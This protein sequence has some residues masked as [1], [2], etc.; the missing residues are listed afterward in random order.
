MNENNTYQLIAV[1]L[2][3]LPVPDMADR[4]WA[5][6]EAQLDIDLPP[7]NGSDDPGP[8]P[9]PKPV[10]KQIALCA[11]TIAVAISFFQLIYNRNENLKTTPF[12]PEQNQ[13]NNIN[14]DT[15]FTFS[16]PPSKETR[17]PS[18]LQTRAIVTTENGKTDSSSYPFP[19][20]K[21]PDK[22]PEIEKDSTPL[23]ISPVVLQPAEDT[24]PAKRLRGVPLKESDYRIIP[25]KDS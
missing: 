18:P 12:I 22:K 17:N 15:A 9:A 8:A 14:P 6:I 7:D 1:K 4:I 2:E 19:V 21:A 25:K 5:R 11:A 23:V 20:S 13:T 16:K 3:S 10:G 24:I